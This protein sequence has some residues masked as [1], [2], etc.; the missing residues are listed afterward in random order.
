[1]VVTTVQRSR[2][3]LGT[4]ALVLAAVSAI[5]LVSLVIGHVMRVTSRPARSHWDTSS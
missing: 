5:D 1:M 3:L 4:I 2:S